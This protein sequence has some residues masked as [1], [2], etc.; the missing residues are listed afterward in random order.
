M[1]SVGHMCEN[2]HSSFLNWEDFQKWEDE[3]SHHVR[4]EVSEYME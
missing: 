1:I 2:G 3:L 4:Q